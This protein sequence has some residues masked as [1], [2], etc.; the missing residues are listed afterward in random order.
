MPPFHHPAYLIAQFGLLE[1][2]ALLHDT[3][4]ALELHH[5]HQFGIAIYNHVGVMGDNN[6]LTTQFVF[7]D[8]SHD[9]VVY[10]VVVE[11]VFRLVENNGLLTESQQKR[12]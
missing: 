9:Q 2:T 8:L 7:A 1:S 4:T 5:M 3:L 12:Q 6:E 11:V 10:Q